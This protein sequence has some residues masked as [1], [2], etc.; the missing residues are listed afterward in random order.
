MDKKKDKKLYKSSEDL[1]NF[2]IINRLTQEEFAKKLGIS[3][4]TYANWI[5]QGGVTFGNWAR[6]EAIGSIDVANDNQANYLSK[7]EI[8]TQKIR[9][10]TAEID[11]L[12]LE[13]ASKQELRDKI[14]KANPGKGYEALI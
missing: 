3:R 5:K 7:D 11:I 13:I 6:I 10:L 4:Q 8:T 9:S 12:R 1:R 2:L 14:I